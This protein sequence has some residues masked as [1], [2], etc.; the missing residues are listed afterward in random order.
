MQVERNVLAPRPPRRTR[1]PAIDARAADSEDELSIMLGIACADRVPA[2][3][4]GWLDVLGL[5][6]F[7]LC[8][9][10]G[11]GCD[12]NEYGIVSQG[13]ES[14]VGESHDRDSVGV[15]AAMDY[16]NLAGKARKQAQRHLV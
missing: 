2:Q 11:V 7:G 5:S 1:W 13:W 8:Q 14:R 15:C 3:V 9:R 6:R 4:V 16:P 10:H 12:L